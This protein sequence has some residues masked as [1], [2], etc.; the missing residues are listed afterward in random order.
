MLWEVRISHTYI[1]FYILTIT[2]SSL[3][4]LL[5]L[6]LL[7]LLLLHLLLSVVVVVVLIVVVVLY[8]FHHHLS[9]SSSSSSFCYTNIISIISSI[10]QLFSFGRAAPLNL[11]N[12][13]FPFTIHC[14]PLV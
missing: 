6:L 1:S 11:N 4:L 14:V 12:G 3:L 9:S 5:L 13:K 7:S 2:S 8:H 10:V